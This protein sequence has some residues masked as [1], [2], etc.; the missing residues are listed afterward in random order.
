[1]DADFTVVN[2]AGRRFV[3]LKI[4]AL[5]AFDSGWLNAA[6]NAAMQA[7]D[8]RSAEIIDSDGNHI[9]AWKRNA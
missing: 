4:G 5:W 7:T 2:N 1:M 9:G 6:I 3:A 8:A